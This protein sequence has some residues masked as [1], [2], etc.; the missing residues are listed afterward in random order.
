MGLEHIQHTLHT[1][2]P[3]VRALMIF[4]ANPGDCHSKKSHTPSSPPVS[5]DPSHSLSVQGAQQVFTQVEP[6][7]RTLQRPREEMGQ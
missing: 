1:T 2:V 7:K 3:V 6:V 4:P 5:S